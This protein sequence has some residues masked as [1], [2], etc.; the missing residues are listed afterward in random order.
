MT[1]TAT[2]NY[3]L[4][5]QVLS[6]CADRAATYDRENRFFSE[7]FELL[8]QAGYLLAAVPKELGGL[9]LSLSQICQEQRRLAYH[10]AATA[11]GTNMH[12]VATGVAADLYRKGDQSLKWLLQEAARGE[13]FAYG[14]GE[15]GNDVGVL[16][17][18]TKVERAD[19]G[20]RFIGH[21]IFGTLTPVWT[22]FIIHGADTSDPRAPKIVH[23][24]MRRDSP[25]YQIKETWDT[26]GMR[27]TRSEDTVLEGVVVP[28]R[29]IARVVSPGWAA[30]QYV[31]AIFG[32]GMPTFGAV[33]TGIAERARDLAITSVKRKTSIAGM[34]RSMAYHPEMQHA[35]AAMLLELEAMRPHL[36]RIADDWSNEV[37]HGDQWPAK[38]V[39]V[40]NHCVEGAKKVVDL[41]MDVSGGSG[42][43]KRNELERLYRDVRCGGFH[44]ANNALVHEIVGKT[45]LG[46]LGEEPRWG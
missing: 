22:R 17:S 30:D 11:L 6:Q 8:R 27:A 42:M 35:V 33:Y 39:A 40:K 1:A 15:M 43:F 45:A 20:Y 18:T 19:G 34:T 10:S 36:E 31:L 9:G 5:E 23:G 14:Y 26:L 12:I 7:D 44:P 25:G 3:I 16:Y 21:K 41:A 37:D 13:V 24:V 32:W 29:Y 28:D 38:L 46:V 4:S 2:P